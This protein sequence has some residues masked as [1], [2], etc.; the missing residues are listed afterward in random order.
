M[1]EKPTY[2]ELEQRIQ[3]LEQAGS[4]RKLAKEALQESE[5]KYSRLFHHSNDGIFIHDLDANIIDANQKVLA[6]FGYTKSEISSIKIPMLH[7]AEALE[8]SKWAFETIIRDGFVKFEIDFYKKNGE[9]FSTEVSSS[10]FEI[11]GKKVIQ[12]IVRD[13]TERKL[14]EEALRE[15][16]SRYRNLF[17]NNHSVMLIIDPES[18]DIVDANPAAISYYGWTHGDLTCKKITHINTL[19][20]EQIF[21]EMEHAKKEHRRIFYFRHRLANGD[22]RDVEVY[23]GPIKLYG[24]QLLY[25]IIHDITERKKAEKERD[26]LINELQEVSKEIK[27]LKGIL[28]FC[29]FCKKI[30][31]DKGYWEKVDIYIHRYSQADISHSICPECAKKHYPDLNID[32]D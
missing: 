15:S 8:K 6:L 25:S 12:G 16:E 20:E 11:G 4:K 3:E 17:K 7:P 19:T 26:K 28:P 32:E 22:I 5:E 10:L 2:E 27:T 18:A 21:Q 24:K 9:M 1:P 14:A 13:I 30:R 31:D 23:S 29:T